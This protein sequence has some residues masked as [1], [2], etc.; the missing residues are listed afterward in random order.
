M[1]SA[2][3]LGT[4]N[5]SQ[6][7]SWTVSRSDGIAVAGGT[8]IDN[9]GLLTV[10][11]GEAVTNATGVQ[12]LV[13]TATSTVDN[14]N[15]GGANVT[16]TVGGG[17]TGGT[18]LTVTPGSVAVDRGE[19]Q[20]FT[21]ID[22]TG[23]PFS[24]VDWTVTTIN[25]SPP[26]SGTTI[27][28]RGLLTVGADEAVSGS[29]TPSLIVRASSRQDPDKYGTANVLVS[30]G[31]SGQPAVTGVSVS[32]SSANVAQG[33]HQPFSA[34]VL[35]ANNPSQSVRWTVSRA[36]GI[37]VASGTYID[38]PTSSTPTLYVAAN[39]TATDATGVQRLIVQANSIADG[40]KYGVANITV[41]TAGGSAGGGGTAGTGLIVNPSS[42]GVARGGAQQFTAYDTATG[43]PISAVDW[44]VYRANGSPALSSG[45][46]IQPAG[47]VGVLH[48]GADEVM[49]STAT[50]PAL[51][52]RAIAINSA[53]YGTANVF[54]SSGSTGGG[55]Q[56]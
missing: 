10:G 39:E 31:D 9:S 32:P 50:E 51:I 54:V 19:T 8:S 28:S 7:V 42:I 36:D 34:T 3:V 48:V 44:N 20:K 29:S 49:S 41:T 24:A 1:F 21:A 45:T 13:V 30:L 18:G 37:V 25:N 11:S 52:V 16:V 5:P 53:K 46:S 56:P 26:A 40:T 6:N 12:R 4:N 2:I 15:Y 23:I 55:T 22:D 35:G 43:E 33:G 38:D 14:T 17:G 47:G 27:D